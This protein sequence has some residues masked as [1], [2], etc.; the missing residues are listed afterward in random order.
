[1][2]VYIRPRVRIAL[3]KRIASIAIND[4]T[5]DITFIIVFITGSLLYAVCGVLISTWRRCG[6]EPCI[7]RVCACARRVVVDIVTL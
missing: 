6:C 5:L 1:M 4:G 7:L 2:C 3:S